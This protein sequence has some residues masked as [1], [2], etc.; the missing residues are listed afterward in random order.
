MREHA[1][2]QKVNWGIYLNLKMLQELK[3]FKRVSIL[4]IFFTTRLYYQVYRD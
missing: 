2:I 1:V 3:N 4:A